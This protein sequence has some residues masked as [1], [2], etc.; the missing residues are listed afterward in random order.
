MGL[1]KERYLYKKELPS[2]GLVG[3]EVG[4]KKCFATQKDSLAVPIF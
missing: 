3:G 4:A 1:P 2:F